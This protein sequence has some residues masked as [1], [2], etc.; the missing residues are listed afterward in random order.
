[1]TEAE[2]AYQPMEGRKPSAEQLALYRR[3]FRREKLVQRAF[4][5]GAKYRRRCCIHQRAKEKDENQP[6]VVA[7]DDDPFSKHHKDLMMSRS[8]GDWTKVTARHSNSRAR[9]I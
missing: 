7:L 8:I 9:H 5:K 6:L 1:M 3:A 4:P 2:R